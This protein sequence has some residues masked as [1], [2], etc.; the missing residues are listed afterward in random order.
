MVVGSGI[1]GLSLFTYPSHLETSET[2]RPT[3]LERPSEFIQ[4]NTLLCRWQNRDPER[5]GFFQG[6]AA[7]R[8][9]SWEHI[10]G[11][12]RAE[13][14]WSVSDDKQPSL[15]MGSEVKLLESRRPLLTPSHTQERDL[16]TPSLGWDVRSLWKEAEVRPDLILWSGQ[17]CPRSALG[18]KEN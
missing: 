6:H 12:G 11:H 15:R 13:W 17:S 16:T 14:G 10:R 18:R 9:Q 7:G 4:S 5:R 8:W 3:E 2:Y 1:P